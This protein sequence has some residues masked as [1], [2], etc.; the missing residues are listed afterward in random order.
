MISA[1]D[2]MHLRRMRPTQS[3]S[4]W[5]RFHFSEEFRRLLAGILLRLK[6]ERPST[7]SRIR[8]FVLPSGHAFIESSLLSGETINLNPLQRLNETHP[9]HSFHPFV[10]CHGTNHSWR[11]WRLRCVCTDVV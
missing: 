7:G 11:T 4:K 9:E 8:N 2:W 1:P 10:V 5:C 3:R 6:D